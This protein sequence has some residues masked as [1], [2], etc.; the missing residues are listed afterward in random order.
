MRRLA[1]PIALSLAALLGAASAQGVPAAGPGYV[2]SFQVMYDSPPF[3]ETRYRMTVTFTGEVCG[4]PFTELW[5]FVVTREGAPD[6]PATTLGSFTFETENPATVTSDSWIDEFGSEI[7][8]IDYLL[9]FTPGAPPVLTPSWQTAGEILNVVA[10]PPQVTATARTL[11]NCPAATPPPPPTGTPTGGP[12]PG[13]PRGKVKL[14]G[15]RAFSPITAGQE[16]PPGTVIDVSQGAGVSLTDGKQGKLTIY[17]QRDGV[18]SVVTLAKTAGLVELRLTG[19][20]FKSCAKRGLASAGAK[21]K[22]VRRVW[23]KGKGAFR[24]KGRYASAAIRGTWWLT[25]DYCDRT[26]VQVRQ[27]TM[28]VRDFVKTKNV[29]VKAPKSYSATKRR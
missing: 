26:L 24:T 14:P 17:G 8:R 28:L 27:G 25:A 16:L 3:P 11:E 20:N 7:A 5:T 18:P 10:T 13:Y 12:A 4:N 9:R 22:P 15:E 29:V 23:G 6:G 19:G 1:L 2:A 21:E